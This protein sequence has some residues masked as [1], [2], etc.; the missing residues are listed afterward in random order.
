MPSP[1]W[2]IN[3]VLESS[4]ES[5]SLEVWHRSHSQSQEEGTGIYYPPVLCRALGF[6]YF[7]EKMIISASKYLGTRLLWALVIQVETGHPWILGASR[8][9]G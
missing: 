4:W 1:S 3:N 5:E 9:A 2:T 6:R 8:H 7:A